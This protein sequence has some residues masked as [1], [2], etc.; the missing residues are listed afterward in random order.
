MATLE[1]G[2]SPSVAGRHRRWWHRR[3]GDH[4]PGWWLL[5]VIWQRWMIPVRQ[6]EL[7]PSSTGEKQVLTS[8]STG[9]TTHP[10]PESIVIGCHGMSTGAPSSDRNAHERPLSSWFQ[11][12]PSGGGFSGQ[13]LRLRGHCAIYPPNL[14]SDEIPKA[15]NAFVSSP[16]IN[17]FSFFLF[18]CFLI[19]FSNSF[20][21]FYPTFLRFE[22]MQ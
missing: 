3:C 11:S 13:P 12:K 5:F 10:E 2:P 6:P 1:D 19:F 8:K 9:A 15:F 16:S 21:V 22:L 18:T 4:R 7:N 20:H 14:E 17:P